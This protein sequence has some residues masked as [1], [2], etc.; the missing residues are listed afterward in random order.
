MPLNEEGHGLGFRRWDGLDLHSLDGP[1]SGSDRLHL[2][3]TG[4]L[5]AVDG[6]E[7]H[8]QITQQ[9][10]S[11]VELATNEQGHVDGFFHGVFGFVGCG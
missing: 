8:G 4:L 5:V 2:P 3:G 10:E 9:V 1:E 6:F 7:F 11:I